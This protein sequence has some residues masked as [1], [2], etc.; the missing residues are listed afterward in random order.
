[1]VVLA[2][3]SLFLVP[4]S[5]I[6]S[7]RLVLCRCHCLSLLG[8]VLGGIGYSSVGLVVRLFL[9]SIHPFINQSIHPCFYVFAL[10]PR[11]QPK[12]WRT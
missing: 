11:S 6:P 10:L 5:L 8:D 2:R 12:H 3:M 9:P 1:M 7:F 4:L